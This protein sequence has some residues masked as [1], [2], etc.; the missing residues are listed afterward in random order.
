MYLLPLSDLTLWKRACRTE[1]LEGTVVYKDGRIRSI[2]RRDSVDDAFV[3]SCCRLHAEDDL[4]HAAA[5]AWQ[6]W[7][8]CGFCELTKG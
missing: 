1:N 6:A 8:E 3:G 4:R 7:P 5:V 2:F